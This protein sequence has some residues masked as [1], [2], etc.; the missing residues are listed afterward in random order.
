M[1]LKA[2]FSASVTSNKPT[3]WLLVFLYT[4]SMNQGAKLR[5]EEPCDHSVSQSLRRDQVML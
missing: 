4:I 5:L 1:Q 2:V 3:L